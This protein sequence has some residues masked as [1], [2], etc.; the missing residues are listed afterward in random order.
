MAPETILIGF[1]DLFPNLAICDR[2]CEAHIVASHRDVRFALEVGE[3]SARRGAA[4]NDAAPVTSAS[5]RACAYPA[6]LLL[7]PAQQQQNDQ[8][9]ND[10]SEA[11]TTV[12]A[13]AVKRTAAN[14]AKTAK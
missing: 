2:A 8:D 10:Q 3:L 11:A 1:S 4:C 6:E 13:R 14:A 12:I 9:D 7:E 5:V